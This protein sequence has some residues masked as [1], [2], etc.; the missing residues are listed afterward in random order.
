MV[1][2][3]P[4]AEKNK[5]AAAFTFKLHL[6]GRARDVSLCAR[7]EMFDSNFA[8]LSVAMRCSSVVSTAATRLQSAS[9]IEILIIKVGT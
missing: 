8:A 5:N 1:L 6:T 2:D 9:P 7:H 4:A 3:K